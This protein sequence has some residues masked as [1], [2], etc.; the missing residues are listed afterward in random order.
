MTICSD[1]SDFVAGRCHS[2]SDDARAMFGASVRDQWEVSECNDFREVEFPDDHDDDDPLEDCCLSMQAK[3]SGSEAWERQ[4]GQTPE[5]LLQHRADDASSAWK[6]GP[7]LVKEK[8]L[9]EWAPD[10]SVD[11]RERLVELLV[12][13][14]ELEKAKAKRYLLTWR[15][16]K[17]TVQGGACWGSSKSIPQPVREKTGLLETWEITLSLPV[18]LLLDDKGRDRLL[19][20][21]LM[22][23]ATL[24]RGHP[25]AEFPETV[26]RYGLLCVDQAK[27]ALAGIA[28]ESARTRVEVWGLLPTGQTT[29]FL[30]KG[31]K[32][33]EV[34]VTPRHPEP[35]DDV[36]DL[37]MA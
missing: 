8:D 20:H 12:K 31:M 16:T 33:V 21:E 32:Q 34:K 22:H 27:L 26:A 29:L 4:E 17:W 2:I 23:A 28:H 37:P 5:D 25:V 3:L 30:G 14:P 13:C 19:H 10:L 15:T 7:R 36:D 11:L 35:E 18:W 1:C 6:H 24:D 9:D